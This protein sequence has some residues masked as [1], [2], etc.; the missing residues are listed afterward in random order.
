ME[1][2]G[3]LYIVATPIGNLGDISARALETLGRSL[4]IGAE[5]TRVARKLLDYYEISTKTVSIQEHSTDHELEQF[6][7]NLENGDLA[8]ISDAGTPGISDPGSKLV[9]LA[10]SMGYRV[11][12][13]PGA[14]AVIAALSISGFPVNQFT[15]LG[16]PPTKKGR[17][18]FFEQLSELKETVALYESKH[19][20][21]KTLEQLPADRKLFVARELTKLHESH[22]HGTPA[23]VIEQLNADSS[24]GEFVIIIAPLNWK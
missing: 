3:V 7:T 11:E 17:Q 23:E 10:R 13:I 12:S 19:R 9:N 22:Y 8:Y 5:D 16:F 18:T 1:R 20:I 21:V 6:V 24:K 15:F 4:L 14:S 2:K